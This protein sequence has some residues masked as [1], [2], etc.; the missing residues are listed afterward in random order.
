MAAETVVSGDPTYA[1]PL[2]GVELKLPV[3]HILEDSVRAAVPLDV[4]EAEVEIMSTVLDK[5][6]ITASVEAVRARTH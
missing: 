1:G 3:F 4:Y 2:A 6:S 5:A